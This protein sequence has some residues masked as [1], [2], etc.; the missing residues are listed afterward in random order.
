MRR[1]ATRPSC[2]FFSFTAG[3]HVLDAAF[4]GRD[5]ADRGYQKG[6][7]HRQ[8]LGALKTQ[9]LMPLQD[10]FGA[11][12]KSKAFEGTPLPSGDDKMARSET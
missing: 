9:H 12:M 7:G 5:R 2:P 10:G 8:M 6:P 1:L 11:R 3:T 4:C